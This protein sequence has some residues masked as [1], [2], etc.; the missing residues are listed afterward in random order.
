[1]AGQK[2]PVHQPRDAENV[3]EELV[4]YGRLERRPRRARTA[5]GTHAVRGA[6]FPGSAISCRPA[7]YARYDG[8]TLAETNALPIDQSIYRRDARDISRFPEH[9]TAQIDE[10][11]TAAHAGTCQRA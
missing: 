6:T 5:Q 9:T 7:R 1:L 10:L 3:A 8:C 4:A 11:I 2:L